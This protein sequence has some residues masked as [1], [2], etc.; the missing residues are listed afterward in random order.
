M[1]ISINRLIEYDKLLANIGITIRCDNGEYKLFS[2]IMTEITDV[3]G[4]IDDDIIKEYVLTKLFGVRNWAAVYCSIK[5]IN[6]ENE[7]K[8][9]YPIYIVHKNNTISIFENKTAQ[10]AIPISATKS[11][12]QI[13]DLSLFTDS[14]IL[15]MY[16]NHATFLINLI[17][18]KATICSYDTKIDKLLLEA[19]ELEDS[20]DD[21]YSTADNMIKEF[22]QSEENKKFNKE[23]EQSIKESVKYLKKLVK[24]YSNIK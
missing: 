5:Q 6:K 10:I 17:T 21:L 22:K 23:A 24:G 9:N 13:V 3:F 11:E 14:E 2:D 16:N 18:C 12:L 7:I 19:S 1:N 8:A 20:Q 4:K 15:D